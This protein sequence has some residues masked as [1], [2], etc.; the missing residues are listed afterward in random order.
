MV[1]LNPSATD[2]ATVVAEAHARN[3]GVLI[4]KALNSGHAVGAASEGADSDPV[5]ASLEFVFSHAGVSSVIIG[6][7]TPG[8]LSHNIACAVAAAESFPG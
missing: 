5:R 2:D 6:S 7:I 3:K 8:H 4:K 1:T